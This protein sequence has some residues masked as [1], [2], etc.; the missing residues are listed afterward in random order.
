VAGND[1]NNNNNN[2][3]NNDNNNNKIALLSTAHIIRKTLMI[4]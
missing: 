1:V 2:N 4:K 3:N